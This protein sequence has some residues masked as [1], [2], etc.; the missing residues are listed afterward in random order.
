MTDLRL[1]EREAAALLRGAGVELDPA[2]VADLTERTE[3]WPA[4]LY[5]AAL[6]MR[7]GAPDPALPRRS[8]AT[9]GWSPSTSAYELL[10]RLPDAEARFLTQHV[11]ARADVRRPLRR[12]ARDHAVRGDAR[13]ARAL[14]RLRRAAR[15]AR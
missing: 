5:L 1:D 10:S 13:V 15:P 3:G 4:G 6:S 14:E 11:G 9:T 8:P 2:E 7:A 12:G